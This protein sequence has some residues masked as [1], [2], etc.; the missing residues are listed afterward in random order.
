MKIMELFQKKSQDLQ[1]AQPVTLA[2]LGD[3]VTQGCFEVYENDSGNLEPI[4]DVASAYHSY[5]KQLLTMLYPSVPINIINAGISGDGAPGGLKRL[6][7][8]VLK[9]HPDFTVVCFGLNDCGK[10]VGNM[11][12]Y[13]D[14][15]SGIFSELKKAEIETVFMTPNM[16][17]TKIS[18]HLKEAG[19]REVAKTTMELQKHGVLEHY[20]DQA[21]KV[22]SQYQI[23]ICDCYLDWI[24][25]DEMGIDITNHLSNYINHPTRQMNWLFSIRLLEKMLYE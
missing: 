15:L 25:M 24:K 2:F 14:A 23:P 4:F 20:L 22:C 9:Y 6:E 5:L 16:M 8:D 3:S 10:G 19:L 11:K 17:N 21:R 1:G 7:R 12:E 18:C 13:T